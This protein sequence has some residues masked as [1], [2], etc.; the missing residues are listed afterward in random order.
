VCDYTMPGVEQA[1]L[2]GAWVSFKGGGEF[3]ALEPG[4]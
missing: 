4:R 3:V 1:R 2:A